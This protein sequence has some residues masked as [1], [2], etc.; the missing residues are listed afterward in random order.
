MRASYRG[1]GTFEV[2]GRLLE[3][4]T[5]SGPLERAELGGCP[6]RGVGWRE[7]ESHHRRER[8][9]DIW[10]RWIRLA[11]A[12]AGGNKRTVQTFGRRRRDEEEEVGGERRTRGR[13]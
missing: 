11:L 12:A 4:E 10:K 5:L 9:G 8:K 1:V 2:E 6:D 13:W 7:A 3:R